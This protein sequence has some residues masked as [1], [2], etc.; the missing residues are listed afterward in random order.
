MSGFA[1][2]AG[3]ERHTT[4]MLIWPEIYQHTFQDGEKI[5]IILIDTQGTFDDKST[6]H[7]CVTI[8]A[9]SL[10]ISSFQIYNVFNNIQED[11]LQHLQVNLNKIFY[12][13]S[14]LIYFQSLI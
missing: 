9:L 7:N 6:I 11:H 1:W 5:S 3:T 8:F 12:A 14:F 13:Y 4:G 10:M 2:R